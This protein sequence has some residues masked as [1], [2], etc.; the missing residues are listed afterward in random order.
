[1][2]F[3]RIAEHRIEGLRRQPLF[4]RAQLQSYLPAGNQRHSVRRVRRRMSART[5][6]SEGAIESV[7]MSVFPESLK[8]TLSTMMNRRSSASTHIMAL[9]YLPDASKEVGY[10]GNVSATLYRVTHDNQQ[11][12]LQENCTVPGLKLNFTRFWCMSCTTTTSRRPTSTFKNG[13]MVVVAR[14]DGAL[15][16]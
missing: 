9:S 11:K 7:V 2:R 8:C 5:P 4:P 6:C 3:S 15:A 1:M 14:S 12:S 10:R 16:C 13:E